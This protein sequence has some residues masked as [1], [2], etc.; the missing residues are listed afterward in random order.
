MY[1][2]FPSKIFCA[3]LIY[4]LHTAGRHYCHFITFIFFLYVAFILLD[5]SMVA[6]YCKSTSRIVHPEALDCDR[7]K[8][9]RRN[10][11][12]FALMEKPTQ[13]LKLNSNKSPTRRINFQF[14]ILT[15]IYSSTSF[16]RSPAHHQEFND[17]SGSLWFYLRIVVIAVLLFVVWPVIVIV[18]LCSWSGRLT[19]PTTNTARLSLRYEG[20]T[21]GCHCN[22]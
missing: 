6:S 7:L 20:K 15:F 13:T 22:H 18:A 4:V 16:G 9:N 10:L 19:G 11:N 21:R 12:Y 2:R 3:F 5:F 8:T 17:Y 1:V 14:I